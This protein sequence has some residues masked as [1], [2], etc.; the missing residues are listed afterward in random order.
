[1]NRNFFDF[2]TEEQK[3]VI[4]I[5]EDKLGLPGNVIEKDLWVC[6]LLEQLF[7]LPLKMAFKGGT[8][9]SKVFG[10]INR[11]SEDVDVTI[12]YRNFIG[13]VAFE[14]ANRSQIKK[15]S[16]DLK[17]QL[18]I[19]AETKIVLHLKERSKS[20]FPHRQI[21]ITLSEDGEKLRFFYPTLV[22]TNLGYLR[23]H[24]L[25]EFGIRNSSEPCNQHVISTL[26]A[27]V[28]DAS[29]LLPRPAVTT[30]SPV[31]T[32]WE[33]ATLIHVECNRK[34]LTQSP[35]RLSRH[36]YD[37]HMLTHSW[38]IDEA[39]IQRHVLDN[40]VLHK[41]AFFNSAYTHY[42]QCLNGNLRLIPDDADK[43]VLATDYRQMKEAGMFPIN[44][45]E[46][47]EIMNSLHELELRCNNTLPR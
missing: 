43:K 20:L 44:P 3:T 16:N 7:D 34:R 9:L 25:I 41:K 15:I 24:V 19:L 33:K 40:V 30:L 1:M 22:N 4:R 38:V 10:L 21:D 29:I 27:E 26:L 5:A 32:F 47:V 46:F 31:R 35:A 2:S 28:L 13:D 39:F 11:F 17:L 8:S 6:W 45:P 37:L 23:D 36:W 18:K 42:D 12:D 14:Q